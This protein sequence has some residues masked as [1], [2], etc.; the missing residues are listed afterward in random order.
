MRLDVV[1][2]SPLIIG[3]PVSLAL[4]LHDSAI[5]CP[6]YEVSVRMNGRPCLVG[7]PVG[8]LAGCVLLS[9]GLESLYLLPSPLTVLLSTVPF[10]SVGSVWTDA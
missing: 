5:A 6:T 4:L 1:C 9:S 8:V 10:P 2:A 7:H 3:D